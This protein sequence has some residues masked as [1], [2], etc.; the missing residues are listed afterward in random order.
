[1]VPARAA[2]TGA[3]DAVLVAAR[4]RL[5]VLAPVFA[6]GAAA[7]GAVRE[8]VAARADIAGAAAADESP[9]N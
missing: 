5:T 7:R 1:M 2:T 9:Q 8:F 3:L 4:P 6:A